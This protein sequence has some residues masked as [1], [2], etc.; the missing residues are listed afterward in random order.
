MFLGWK[1]A[2]VYGCISG[3]DG[4]WLCF[5]K[6]FFDHIFI[7]FLSSFSHHNLAIITKLMPINFVRITNG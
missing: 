1:K 2:M 7:A 3:V 4:G 6:V 5:H